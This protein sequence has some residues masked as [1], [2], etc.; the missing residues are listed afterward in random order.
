[1]ADKPRQQRVSGWRSGCT[2]PRRPP[3]PAPPRTRHRARPVLPPTLRRSVPST[4]WPGS[5]AVMSAAQ[6]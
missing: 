5:C 4:R 3:V 6:A 2:L 1:V